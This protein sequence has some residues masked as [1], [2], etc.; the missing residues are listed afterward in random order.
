MHC[1][2]S[3]GGTGIICLV[4]GILFFIQFIFYIPNSYDSN[5]FIREAY[6]DK[7]YYF[8]SNKATIKCDEIKNEILNKTLS[9][10]FP[11]DLNYYIP[12]A[13]T[14]KWATLVLCLY[15]FANLIFKQLLFYL[16][17]SIF[18]CEIIIGIILLLLDLILN[19]IGDKTIMNYSEFLDCKNVNRY[20]FEKYKEMNDL[21]LLS[22]GALFYIFYIFSYFGFIIN[23]NYRLKNNSY[24]FEFD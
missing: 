19:D 14:I 8:N 1:N 3:I 11:I 20:S 24:S 7:Y 9:E 15:I 23:R 6:N 2:N 13:I 5:P 10:V 4:V 16:N 22:L 12:I 18:Y 17:N 21:K